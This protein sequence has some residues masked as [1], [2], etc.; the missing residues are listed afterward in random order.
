MKDYSKSRFC[1]KSG[2][3]DRNKVFDLKVVDSSKTIQR[4]IEAE[5]KILL[6]KLP[7]KEEEEEFVIF[8]SLKNNVSGANTSKYME[9]VRNRLA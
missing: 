5:E 4:Q 8:D 9:S 2:L 6:P 1:V 3:I 7:D